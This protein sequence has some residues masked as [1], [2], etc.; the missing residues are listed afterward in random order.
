MTKFETIIQLCKIALGIYAS[1][2]L[3]LIYEGITHFAK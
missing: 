3:W 1:V 2:M